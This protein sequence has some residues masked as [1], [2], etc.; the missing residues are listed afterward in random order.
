MKK[1]TLLGDSIRQIGYGLKVPQLL[2][3]EYEVFQPD[4]NCRF[5]KYTLRGLYDWAEGMKDSTVIHW[6]NGIWDVADLFG[7]G[8]FTPIEL[9]V[10]EMVRIAKILKQRAKTVIFATTTPLRF[11]NDLKNEKIQSYNAAVVPK[12]RELGVVINDLYS[13]ID[14][15][16]ENYVRADDKIHLSEAGIDRAAEAVA[17]IIRKYA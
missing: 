10:D 11:E 12:L 5:A 14:A 6:N 1:V 9:Y 8:N 13:V 16:L 4:D 2:G 15:D 7:E 3:D 17:G